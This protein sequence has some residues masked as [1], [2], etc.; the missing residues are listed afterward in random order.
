MSGHH[1]AG[2]E[3]RGDKARAHQ[4]TKNIITLLFFD[5]TQKH[6]Q[7]SFYSQQSLTHHLP[8]PFVT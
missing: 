2:E 5:D 3:W 8:S 1:D 4:Q 7:Q 6:S